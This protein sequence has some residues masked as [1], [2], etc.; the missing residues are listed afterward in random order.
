MVRWTVRRGAGGVPFS[1]QFCN[2]GIFMCGRFCIL[3]FLY[4]TF[5]G[6][7]RGQLKAFENFL[8]C[9]MLDKS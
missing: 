9:L 8:L 2:I 3:T 5:A 6:G 1:L 7:R 4:V